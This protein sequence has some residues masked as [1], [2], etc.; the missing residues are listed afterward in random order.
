MSDAFCHSSGNTSDLNNK[1]AALTADSCNIADCCVWVN[2]T[3]CAAGNANG[4]TIIT[5]VASDTDYYFH[6]YQCYGNNC[7]TTAD[8]C[9]QYK[10]TDRNI[11]DNC[12]APLWKE[13][14][15]SAPLPNTGWWKLETKTMVQNDM[16]AWASLP[17]YTHRVSCYGEDKSKW[18]GLDEKYKRV[19]GNNGLV[20]CNQY[21]NNSQGKAELPSSWNGASCV[22][23]GQNS[24]ED[25]SNVSGA[26]SINTQCIC[27]KN[28]VTPWA[29]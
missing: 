24:D 4:P 25:C 13:A 11:P 6:K 8:Q 23:A 21:C 12:L 28:D 22:A 27:V 1:C 14:G 5:G 7:E 15:C 18:P 16:S 17:D 20:S 29:T 9:L 2:G 10:N 26:S 3:K 19:Y